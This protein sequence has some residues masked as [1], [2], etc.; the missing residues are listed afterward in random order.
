MAYDPNNKRLSALGND[1]VSTYEIAT[2]LDDSRLNTRGQRDLGMLCT[3]PKIDI[4]A[5][6]KP[7]VVAD[8]VKEREEQ[9]DEAR[10]L[11]AYGF[12]WWNLSLD[13]DAPFGRSATECMAK[14]I[15]KNGAWEYKRPYRVF[16]A[17]D[18]NGYSHLARIPYQYDTASGNLG[19]TN[20]FRA[21]RDVNDP[22][23]EIT[24]SQMPDFSGDFNGSVSD[25][26]LVIIYR[27][28]NG[29]VTNVR[30]T[31]YK[32]S[33]LDAGVTTSPESFSF[34]ALNGATSRDWYVLFAATNAQSADDVDD[35][36]YLYL[37]ESLMLINQRVGVSWQY[38]TAFVYGESFYGLVP[39]N[40][41][42]E[43]ITGRNDEASYLFLG[44]SFLNQFENAINWRI[45]FLAWNEAEGEDIS[46]AWEIYTASGTL[47]KGSRFYFEDA[48]DT[49]EVSLRDVPTPTL[50]NTKIAVNFWY[51]D[52]ANTSYISKHFDL[53]NGS[54]GDYSA[55]SGVTLY[56]LIRY[57]NMAQPIIL[58]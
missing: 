13:A 3:S 26:N 38:E 41:G 50:G 32:V 22:K 33:D 6:N 27:Q 57:A 5:K 25:L 37:P 7:F 52:V 21:L 40:S 56:D 15:E 29:T 11:A 46:S 2:C 19:N 44:M 39:A 53:L 12:Y 45:Q 4:W 23:V 55:S 9:S 24:L 16:R 30:F 18:F 58:E 48:G 51:K 35:V 43:V 1:A 31:P 42:Y 49:V 28:K 14:A 36:F 20:S 34:P 47:S 8:G 10:R 17:L 54:L